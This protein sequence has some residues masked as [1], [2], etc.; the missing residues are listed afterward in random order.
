MLRKLML[1]IA[2]CGRQCAYNTRK[3]ERPLSV[4]QHWKC[5]YQRG[6]KSLKSTYV[7]AGTVKD[8]DVW[9]TW[10]T[11]STFEHELLITG[12]NEKK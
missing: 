3:L 11:V 1:N 7:F 8:V 6:N 2:G 5:L 10:I 12:E 9:V 4:L